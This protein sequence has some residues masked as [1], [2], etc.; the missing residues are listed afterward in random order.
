MAT[1]KVRVA[2][3]IAAIAN[4]EV[5]DVSEW[6]EEELKRGQRRA[7]DGTFRGRPGKLVPRRV[8]DELR[9]R[10]ANEFHEMVRQ[11]L[12]PAMQVV[13]DMAKGQTD[14]DPTRLKA[15]QEII[16][17]FAGKAPEK[18]EITHHG[19]PAYEEVLLAGIVRDLP[20]DDDVVDAELV[21]PDDDEWWDQ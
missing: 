4:G 14:P 10:T 20:P 19:T 5:D 3:G 7:R 8:Y 9:R 17:R 16:N 11:E 13:V 21:T 6:D 1:R 18:V 12:V 2:E 15:A